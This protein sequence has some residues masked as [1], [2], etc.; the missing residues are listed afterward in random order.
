M[1]S[2]YEKTGEGLREEIKT[3]EIWFF[4]VSER[5]N[6]GKGKGKI[7]PDWTKLAV[8]IPV[9]VFPTKVPVPDQAP[10]RWE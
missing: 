10:I 1:T 7:S 9:S 3:D 5:K 6:K 2:R 8:S 4:K